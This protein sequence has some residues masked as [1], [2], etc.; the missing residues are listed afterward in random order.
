[1]DHDK[2][3]RDD[4]S[5]HG[6]AKGQEKLPDDLEKEHESD[7]ARG[8]DIEDPARE[9][10]HSDYARGLDHEDPKREAVRPDYAR[11]QDKED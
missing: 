3:D 2:H 5:G 8:Q 4:H 11:G 9:A 10:K 6:F 7:F 1:M